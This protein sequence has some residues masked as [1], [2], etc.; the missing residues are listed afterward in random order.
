MV[1]S[2]LHIADGVARFA[3]TYYKNI[4][5]NNIDM[6][7]VLYDSSD[8]FCDYV[9][10]IKNHNGQIYTLPSLKNLNKHLKC[11]RNILKKGNYDII[12]DNSLIN[13]I[14]LMKEAKKAKIPVR[15]LHAHA[16][17]LGEN[18]YKEFRNRLLL[19]F[20]KININTYAACSKAAA[21]CLFGYAQ[22][23]LL[24][25][26]IYGENYFF[27]EKKRVEFRHQIGLSNKKIVLTVGRVAEQKN[28]FF[29]VNVIS[30][31]IKINPDIVYLW[32]GDGPLIEKL[33]DYV[34]S[35]ELSSQI[36]F[37]GNRTN[38]EKYYTAADCFFLP[39]L[40][41]GLPVSGVEAQ[42]SGIPCIFSDAITRELAYIDVVKYLSLKKSEATWAK[43]LLESLNCEV[44]RKKAV[45]YFLDSSFSDMNAGNYLENFYEECVKKSY[46]F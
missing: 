37:L 25:N 17:R 1:V 16:T 35:L 41:E 43:E 42:A 44:D 40:F 2:N 12:H 31:A 28:P 21:T 9:D 27:D 7:F 3:M 13:T 34:E 18:R 24:H 22:Y 30:Q 11:C 15:I 46:V 20:L 29:A 5:H 6:D 8:P 10:E 45:S 32:I 36:K 4:D 19:P 23:T 39:S 33:R 14:P 38:L 26:V